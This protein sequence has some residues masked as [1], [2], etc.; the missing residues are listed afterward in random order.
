LRDLDLVVHGGERVA[1]VAAAGGGESLLAELLVGVRQPDRG[2]VRRNGRDLTAPRRERGPQRTPPAV[3]VAWL[4]ATP[5]PFPRLTVYENVLVAAMAAR[6]RSRRVSE[7]YA[8]RA[9][10]R[11]DLTADADRWPQ[12]LDRASL[13]RLDAARAIAAPRDLVVIDQ[14]S[15]HSDDRVVSLLADALDDAVQ[16]GAALLWVEQPD[17]VPGFV[18]RLVVLGHGRILSDATPAEV[19]RS[20]IL[21]TW[22]PP[23]AAAASSPGAGTA[24]ATGP[25][26]AA[27]AGDTRN[28]GTT[29][30]GLTDPR[31]TDSRLTDA[32]MRT[33]PPQVDLPT[34]DGRVAP[35]PVVGHVESPG[36]H[37]ARIGSPSARLE[38]SGWA[39]PPPPASRLTGLALAVEPGEVVALVGRRGAGVGILLRSIAGLAE[40]EGRL[41]LDGAEVTGASTAERA[42]LGLGYVPNDGGVVEGLTVA[43]HLGLAGVR[44]RRR[45]W[46]TSTLYD[47]FPSLAL[48]ADRR[49]GEL[50]VLERRSLALARALAANPVILL[51]DRPAQGLTARLGERL[52]VALAEVGRH[53]P[54]LI[55]EVPGGP[56]MR[57]ASRVV[58]LDG[59]LAPAPERVTP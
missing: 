35:E 21:G 52:L 41:W 2:R 18:E 12:A 20:G 7:A 28:S 4:S 53:T 37:A 47:L 50:P 42:R 5:R 27:G 43:E 30:S 48:V 19:G 34:G 8:R 23:S 58:M 49:A 36:G 51:V 26:T 39:V 55:G 6:R 16:E 13:I 33:A 56:T 44:R 40:A 57:L 45:R 59:G 22:R 10:E 38:L 14:P 3:G 46:T 17:A 11:T 25:T 54:L 1:V 24:A 32:G 29:D 31:P 15:A 9:L